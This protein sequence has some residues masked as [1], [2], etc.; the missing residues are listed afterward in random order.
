[1]RRVRGRTPAREPRTSTEAGAH[2]WIRT[3]AGAGPFRD[4]RPPLGGV[5]L[6]VPADPTSS[7][8]VA[9]VSAGP[10][11]ATRSARA[12]VPSRPVRG[13]AARSPRPAGQVV[14]GQGSRSGR[15][16]SSVPDTGRTCRSPRR[17]I[18]T[19]GRRR[20]VD[21]CLP[22]GS[23]RCVE[24]SAVGRGEMRTAGSRSAAGGTPSEGSRVAEA[25]HRV[26]RCSE[27]EATVAVTR[28]RGRPVSAYSGRC[29]GRRPAAGC[30]GRAAVS[31][32]RGELGT[33]A[34]GGIPWPGWRTGHPALWPVPSPSG[35]TVPAWRM[36]A[37]A[38]VAS[39]LAEASVLK[40]PGRGGRLGHFRPPAEPADGARG[41][42]D[43][44]PARRGKTP[45]RE[46]APQRGKASRA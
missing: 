39:R 13:P 34:A 8:I 21:L 19:T 1:V 32:A 25:G 12:S 46:R 29:G 23:A 33:G 10:G 11:A 38:V 22:G 5:F 16:E 45:G 40:A 42:R 35:R 44:L 30:R 14:S 17:R 3:P 18:R 24:Q 36:T 43:V 28:G 4:G 31:R 41:G 37:G 26:R 6:V 9:P 15:R 27:T 7:R 2:R 20:R